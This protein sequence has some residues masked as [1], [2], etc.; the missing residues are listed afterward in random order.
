MGIPLSNTGSPA[1]REAAEIHQATSQEQGGQ[2]E[3]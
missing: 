3:G 2:G 1:G